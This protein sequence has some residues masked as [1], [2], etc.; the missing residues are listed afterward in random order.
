M[1]RI[2]PQD[3]T[4][5]FEQIRAQIVAAATEGSMPAGTRIPTVRALATEL[6]L[7]AGTV[8]KAYRKLEE[9]GVIETRGRAGSVIAAAADSGR[10]QIEV[11]AHELV[12]RARELG[13]SDTR[14]RD[15][16]EDALQ[17]TRG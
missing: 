3:P 2:D 12:L 8:A 7:A 17:R 6:G 4:P 14:V 15:I 1:V 9:D 10:Q 11:R 5:P 13:V 16:L